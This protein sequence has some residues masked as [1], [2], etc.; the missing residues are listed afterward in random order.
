MKSVADINNE[1]AVSPVIGIML[2]IVVTVIIAAVVTM[3]A[4][5]VVSTAEKA[6][7]VVLD[8]NL[9]S[10]H[11]NVKDATA[12][13]IMELRYVSGDIPLDTSKMT[14]ASRW[15]YEGELYSGFYD[16]TQIPESG[17]SEAALLYPHATIQWG[18][19]SLNFGVYEMKP[20][21]SMITPSIN[22]Q[23]GTGEVEPI[24]ENPFWAA[25]FGEDYD[26][27]ERGTDVLFTIT[28]DDFVIFNKEVTIK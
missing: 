9:E 5:G 1:D 22:V 8:V 16:G 3:F 24:D 15:E 20:G 26:T 18:T 21:D 6:P 7:N 25:I 2:M 27:L 19:E 28:Y 11:L 17:G 14:I 12:Y 10:A 23:G 13:P 4:T